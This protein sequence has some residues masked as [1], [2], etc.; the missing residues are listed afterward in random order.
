MEVFV[1]VQKSRTDSD[2]PRRASPYTEYA[3]PIANVERIL[4]DDPT[5]TQSNKEHIKP[6]RAHPYRDIDEDTR[7]NERSDNDELILKQSHADKEF[8]ILTNP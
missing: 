3:E 5:C 7:R 8:P 4:K 6:S 1:I 2:D